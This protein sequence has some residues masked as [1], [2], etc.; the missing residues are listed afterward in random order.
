MYQYENQ[1]AAGVVEAER[2]LIEKG[3]TPKDA[4]QISTFRVFGGANG[5]YGTG[6][7]GMVMS[8]DRLGKR[9]RNSRYLFE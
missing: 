5:G 2:V 4:R 1:V 8:G 9:E 7:Q 3:L 6:I